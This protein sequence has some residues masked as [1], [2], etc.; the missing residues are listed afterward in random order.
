MAVAC[1]TLGKYPRCTVTGAA[2][3]GLDAAPAGVLADPHPPARNPPASATVAKA[4]AVRVVGVGN[5]GCRNDGMSG[6]TPG[7]RGATAVEADYAGRQ[8]SSNISRLSSPH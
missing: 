2:A 6:G 3:G 1:V 4:M 5:D 7:W 8:R